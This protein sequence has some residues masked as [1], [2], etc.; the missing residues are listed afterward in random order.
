MVPKNTQK[1]ILYLLKNTVEL[2]INQIAKLTNISVGSAFKI[3][4]NLEKNKIVIK[5]NISNS[6]IYKLDLNNP[7]TV[8]ICELILLIEKRNLEGYSKVYA[9]EIIKF[10]ESSLIVLFGSILKTNNFNDVDVFFLTNKIKKVNNFCLEISKIRTKPVI[11]LIIRP[12]DLIKESTLNIIKEGVILKGESKFIEVIKNFK[13]ENKV[14][15][16]Q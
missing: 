15:F 4:K 1:I 7:E 16:G 5:K 10:K 11:P 9:Q 14:V 8:K 6:A 3:L 2:S 13:S 12:Q